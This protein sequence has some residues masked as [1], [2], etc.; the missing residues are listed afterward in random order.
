MRSRFAGERADKRGG[1]AGPILLHISRV[2]SNAN[3]PFVAG[4]SAPG[5]GRGAA[6]ERACACAIYLKLNE[7]SVNLEFETETKSLAGSDVTSSNLVRQ[8]ARILQDQFK[9]L[10]GQNARVY[11][12]PG[13]VNL[14]GEHT[15]YND[16]FVMPVAMDMYTW[17]AAAPREDTQ[18]NV[19]SRN[20]SAHAEM[21]LRDTNLHVRGHWSAYVLGV[22]ASLRLAGQKVCG[23]NLLVEGKVPIGA[24]L[25][26]SASVE[27]AAGFALLAAS[28]LSVNP[29]ELATICQR[30]ENEFAGARCGIMDQM[31]ACCGHANYALMLD[32]RSL[33]FQLL[34]LFPDAQFV[35]CNSMV[36]HDH[37]A[38]GYNAR[39]ADCET[40]TRILSGEIPGVR[41]LRDLTLMDLERFSQSLTE[42]VYRRAR[43]VVSENGRVLAARS[44][45]ERGDPE[46]LGRLMRESHRSLRDDYEVS[47]PEVDTLVE[48]ACEQDGVYGSRI[49][50]GG[51]GGCT[52]SLVQRSQVEEFGRSL[53]QRYEQATGKKSDIYIFQAS[54]GAREAL[55]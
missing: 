48:L 51:F 37:A 26:S 4:W 13:R 53:A 45:L 25:S 41:A 33:E 17:V 27:V 18:V 49:T 22:A 21:D 44:A 43:H 1:H 19:Y 40:A 54:D 3:S 46:L 9:E 50:G 6:C 14:I 30:A 20:L 12:A 2:S 31:I 28:G 11:C 32:C 36:K 55:Q 10:Y 16:G 47:C 24:G 38:S 29:V 35:V 39:R 7:F 34:P 15:D 5:V 52:I 42:V 23:A 8:Q